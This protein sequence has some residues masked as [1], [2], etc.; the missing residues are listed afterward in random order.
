MHRS[1]AILLV[2]L[3]LTIG[4]HFLVEGWHKVRSQAIGPA[5]TNRVFSSEAYFR[6]APGPLA[7]AMRSRLGDPDD[8]LLARLTVEPV[9]AGADGGNT[10]P[11]PHIPAALALDWDDYLARFSD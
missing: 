3:R 4:W 10:R 6:E 11:Q 8:E 7:R 9:P 1:T 5:E 2:C